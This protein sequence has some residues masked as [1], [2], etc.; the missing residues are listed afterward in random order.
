MHDHQDIHILVDVIQV[1]GQRAHRE[2]LFDLRQHGPG[3]ARLAGHG[4]ELSLQ[5]ERAQQAHDGFFRI[6]Q[7]LDELGHVVFQELLPVRLEIRYHRAAVGRIGARQTEVQRFAAAGVVG[8]NRLQPGFGGMVLVIRKGLGVDHVQPDLA[9]G[10]RR[11]LLEE[12][13]HPVRVR[14]EQRRLLLG[15]IA[16]EVEIQVDRL[17]ELGE[18]L[19]GAPR[20]GCR[21]DSR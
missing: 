4:I 5:R 1:S 10:S 8:R 18:H 11:D 20:S 7:F 21:D 15:G 17:L 3:V 2:E 16:R 13:A 12:F 6:G 19:P 14:H 9:G